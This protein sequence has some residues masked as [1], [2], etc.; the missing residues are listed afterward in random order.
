MTEEEL[1]AAIE[2]V[3]DLIADP[4]GETAEFD[5]ARIERALDATGGTPRAAAVDLLTQRLG[6]LREEFDVS[7]GSLKAQRSQQIANVRA[8]LRELRSTGGLTTIRA[9]RTDLR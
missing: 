8:Q 5:D 1:A 7:V 6:M 9:I 2:R 4:A 3:R